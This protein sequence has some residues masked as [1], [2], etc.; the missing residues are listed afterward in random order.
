MKPTREA[1]EMLIDRLKHGW[2][3]TQQDGAV[4]ATRPI[5]NMPDQ[6]IT[7]NLD[8]WQEARDYVPDELDFPSEIPF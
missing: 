4:I 5:P 7:V 2:T 6:V 1:A 3:I 8:Q